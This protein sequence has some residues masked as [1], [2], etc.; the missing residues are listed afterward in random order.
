[1]TNE[2]W[3]HWIVGIRTLVMF[4]QVYK[5]IYNTKKKIINFS[6]GPNTRGNAHLDEITAGK[7]SGNQRLE[8]G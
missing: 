4:S 5:V 7:T 8:V 2:N 1:M 3:Q 6:W